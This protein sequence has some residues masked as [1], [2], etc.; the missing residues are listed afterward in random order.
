MN[1]GF[2]WP[3]ETFEECGRQ[4]DDAVCLHFKLTYESK[5]SGEL[6]KQTKQQQ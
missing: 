5:G 3:S 6:K 1:F 4:T 2:D